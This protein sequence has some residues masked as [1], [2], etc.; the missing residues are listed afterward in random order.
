MEEPQAEEPKAIEGV[1]NAQEVFAAALM[2]FIKPHVPAI[3]EKLQAF[4]TWF[5]AFMIQATPVLQKLASVDWEAL[6]RG[7]DELSKNSSAPMKVAARQGWFFNWQ[8]SLGQ[9][10]QLTEHLRDANSSED[11]DRILMA[12]YNESWDVYVELLAN[13]Y[14][15]RK[16]AIEAAVGAH[17]GLAPAGYSLSIPV[18]L[19]QADGIFSELTGAPKA[20]DKVRGE[21]VI[22]GSVWV[23]RQIGEDQL[24]IDLLFPVLQLHEMDILKSLR[25][26]ESAS[27]ESGKD[28]S[29]LNRHQV[30]HGEVSDYGTEMNSV[31]AFSFLVFLALHIP[32]ILQAAKARLELQLT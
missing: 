17:R 4:R 8:D 21:K 13:A 15:A 16:V 18:F 11:I 14:P 5:D 9:T 6:L 27:A 31:K 2:E 10:A 7:L 12:H 29:A 30:L 1:V 19:A 25:D 3:N 22:K 24:A 32:D 23:Q 28:F 26:R 20:M